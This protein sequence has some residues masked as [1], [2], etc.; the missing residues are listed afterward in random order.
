MRDIRDELE[1]EASFWREMS[2]K[3][4]DVNKP[5]C[6]RMREALLLVEIKLAQLEERLH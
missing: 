3:C 5:E 4:S 2:R 6:Q 1:Q